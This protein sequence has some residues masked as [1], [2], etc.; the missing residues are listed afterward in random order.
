MGRKRPARFSRY[1]NIEWAAHREEAIAP[2]VFRLIKSRRGPDA[3]QRVAAGDAGCAA[4]AGRIEQPG[5][6]AVDRGVQV[7]Y[8]TQVPP[9]ANRLELDLHSPQPVGE[10]RVLGGRAVGRSLRDHE[11]QGRGDPVLAAA[12]HAGVGGP[13]AGTGDD[14]AD[15]HFDLR[16]G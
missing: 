15:V 12:E 8:N 2:N 6:V 10:G 7:M 9:R 4:D 13:V 11:R 3:D 14:G 5:P 1:L 16:G